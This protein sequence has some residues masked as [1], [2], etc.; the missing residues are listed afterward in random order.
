[1]RERPGLLSDVEFGAVR[2]HL[3][4]A[5]G[6]AFDES[7]RPVLASVLADRLRV[8]GLPGVAAYL[9]HLAT[10]AGAAER[11][12]LLDSVTVQETHFFRNPPQMEALRRRVLPDLL[13]R[14]AGRG[15]PLTIWSAGCSTGE[16]PYTLAMMLLELSPVK[17][18]PEAVRIVGTDVSAE[19]VRAAA[20]ATY[21]G[22]T[23]DPM[24]PAIADRWLERRPGGT[25]GV[26]DQ[27]RRLVEL[28]VHNLVTQPPPFA[29]GQVDLIVCRNV[30]IY[31]DR[32]TTAR[33]IGTFHD[34]LGEGGYLLLGHSETLWQVSDAFTL[35][36]I[37]DAFLYRRTRDQARTARP[38]AKVRTAA[39][40]RTLRSA[41]GRAEG[42]VAAEVATAAPVGPV[43][44]AA[45]LLE[46][47]RDAMRAGRYD[48]AA[49]TAVEAAT[50]D[51]LVA[52][53]YLLLGEARSTLGQDAAAV[54]ALRKA[55]Y[56]DPALAP[57]HFLLAGALG[58]RGLHAQSAISYRAAARALG[59]RSGQ[60]SFAGFLSGRSP[61]EMATLCHALADEQEA[62]AAQVPDAAGGAAG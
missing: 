23:L 26:T 48:V 60:R 41:P 1:M 46:Q 37:G 40:P 5:A 52:D 17:A 18:V 42:R 36:P 21:A 35:L 59:A 43:T 29:R 50:A 57:A 33:V 34:V 53:A 61:V 38:R 45:D 3:A 56:L 14:C 9:E 30:T 11:Q 13:R 28:R 62:A 54:Q 4:E 6:L 25:F 15:R 7:R 31:F 10:D 27:V 32:A 49:R 47:A 22:R 2:R 8:T 55:V 12:H 20:R 39:K 19:A 24:P 44:Q 16:E 51:P 58:R